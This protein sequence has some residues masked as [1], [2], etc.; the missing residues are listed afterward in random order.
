MCSAGG[1]EK[2]EEHDIS[3]LIDKNDITGEAVIQL[4]WFCHEKKAMDKA[5][6]KSF[7][8]S[9]ECFFETIPQKS[10]FWF[11]KEQFQYVILVNEMWV[12]LRV[13]CQENII[14]YI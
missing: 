5:L 14:L 8:F 9:I 1:R 11:P 6:R 13:F 7:N 2:T 12:K 3:C 4:F 10:Y